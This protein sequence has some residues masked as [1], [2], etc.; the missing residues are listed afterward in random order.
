MLKAL[1]RIVGAVRSAFRADYAEEP[2]GPAWVRLK[3]GYCLNE[4]LVPE[5]SAREALAAP[6]D[7]CGNCEY[8]EA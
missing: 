2:A 7:V 3:C 1:S 5:A 4:K 6:C 8:A